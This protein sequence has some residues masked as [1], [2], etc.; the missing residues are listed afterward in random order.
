[1]KQQMWRPDAA[2]AATSPGPS[3][4]AGH[5]ANT[6]EPEYLVCPPYHANMHAIH[7]RHC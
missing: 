2:R 3:S 5:S 7:A 6:A 4:A 1:M